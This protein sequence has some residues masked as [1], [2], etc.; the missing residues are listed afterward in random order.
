MRVPR[1]GAK[2]GK[3]GRQTCGSRRESKSSV[4][5]AER[6][7]PTVCSWDMKR[8]STALTIRYWLGEH[9]P[10]ATH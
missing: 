10:V 9:P 1:G 8:V 2:E 6:A 4:P 3:A 7:P 5:S